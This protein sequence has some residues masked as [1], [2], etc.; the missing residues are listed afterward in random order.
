MYMKQ[1]PGNKQAGEDD[2]GDDD[3]DDDEWGKAAKGSYL[4][5]F[6]EESRFSQ[7]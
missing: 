7:L 1:K 3:D 5:L 4:T 2:D 6:L